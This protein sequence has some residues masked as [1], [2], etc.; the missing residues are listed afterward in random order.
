LTDVAIPTYF[1]NIRVS[2]KETLHSVNGR[3]VGKPG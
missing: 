3:P 2:Y 1:Y